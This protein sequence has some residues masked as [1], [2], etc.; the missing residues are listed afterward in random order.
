VRLVENPFLRKAIH[1]LFE[2]MRGVKLIVLL[3][4]SL[5]LCAGGNSFAQEAIRF[6][7]EVNVQPPPDMTGISG[8][9]AMPALLKGVQGIRQPAANIRDYLMLPL[10]LVILLGSMIAKLNQAETGKQIMNAVMVPLIAGIF[11][12]ASAWGITFMAKMGD[13]AGTAITQITGFDYYNLGSAFAAY[14]NLFIGTNPEEEAAAI[15]EAQNDE[16]GENWFSRSVGWIGAKVA[17]A[18]NALESAMDGF[19]LAGIMS[20]IVNTIIAGLIGCVAYLT[21]TIIDVMLIV[22]F[23][24]L[25]GASIFAPVFIAGVATG[26]FRTQGINYILGTIA[27]AAWPVAWGVGHLGTMALFTWLAGITDSMVGS[28]FSATVTAAV[29]SGAAIAAV[30]AA[31]IATKVLAAMAMANMFMLLIAVITTAIW[32][33]FV[34][35]W[36]PKFM[37]Q[38]LANGSHMLGGIAAATGAGTIGA[39]GAA[40]VAASGSIAAAAGGLGAAGGAATAGG[41]QGGNGGAGGGA[42]GGAGEAAAGGGAAG[43]AAAGGGLGSRFA[44]GLARTALAA[45]SM[46]GFSG[47]LLRNIAHASN[48]PMHMAGSL[49]R[50]FDEREMLAKLSSNQARTASRR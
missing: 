38:M 49:D 36:G 47:R 46:M 12:A 48:D 8:Y 44:S 4:V 40:M 28:N 17:S 20:W 11:A 30:V 33:L 3:I 43:G 10:A 37:G 42:A 13:D 35:L 24:L 50:T 29:T 34:T 6:Q 32:V 23:F 18:K 45:N 26:F 31:P 27:I 39:I 5:L 9:A 16:E 1:L 41:G 22:R 21:G 2:T 25:V 7:G 19:T 14:A 15:D